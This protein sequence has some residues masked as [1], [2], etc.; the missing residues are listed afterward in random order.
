[1]TAP[2]SL[3]RRALISAGSATVVGAGAFALAAC[4]SP[5]LTGSGS[6]SGSVSNTP[7]IAAGTV[8]TKLADIPVGG[9]KAAT[10]GDAKVV[11]AQPTAGNV[12]C[13]SAIC[14]HQGCAVGAAAKEYD[15]PCH[16]SK[17]NADT[18][19]VLAGPAVT[20][21]TAIKVKVS[22]DSVVTA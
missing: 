22:G 4:S 19:A 14:P 16:G 6:G 13:F 17:F 3:T 1:M 8:V 10:I 18:G 11:L 7:A 15:C 5:V 9:T 2:T 12:V 21:L 20:G